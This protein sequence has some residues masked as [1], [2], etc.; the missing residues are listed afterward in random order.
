MIHK[1]VKMYLDFFTRDG[2]KTTLDSFGYFH[3]KS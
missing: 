2:N 1:L 3:I